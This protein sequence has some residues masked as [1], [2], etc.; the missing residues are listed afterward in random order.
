MYFFYSEKTL[1]T[2]NCTRIIYGLFHDKLMIISVLTNIISC[3]CV[4]IIFFVYFCTIISR[5]KRI[6][7]SLNNIL[8]C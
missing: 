1:I 5:E 8:A 2:T 3:V 6:A 7:F 4:Y